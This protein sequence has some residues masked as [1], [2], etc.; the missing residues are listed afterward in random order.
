MPLRRRCGRTYRPTRTGSKAEQA[1]FMPMPAGIWAAPCRVL[2]LV[3]ASMS[4]GACFPAARSRK[5]TR[6]TRPCR[7]KWR[8]DIP[9]RPPWPIMP[10]ARAITRRSSGRSGGRPWAFL[11]KNMK[12][13]PFRCSPRQIYSRCGRRI[14]M[15]RKALPALILRCGTRPVRWRRNARPTQ[16]LKPPLPM[17]A[18]GRRA[19]LTPLQ[20]AI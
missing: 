6:F 16:G 12:G 7:R 10:C 8:A 3:T 15:S 17:P 1:A 18:R 2:S 20:P 4:F 11:P 19:S 14:W 9:R 5:K 13:K